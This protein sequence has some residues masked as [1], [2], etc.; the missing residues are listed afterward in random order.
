MTVTRKTTASQRR[1][2]VVGEGTSRFVATQQQARAS[3]SAGPS[4]GSGSSRVRE[5]IA[6]NPPEFTG[7]DQR[8]DL[9]DFIDHLHM[10]I[11]VMHATEK[12][13][14]KLSAFRLRDIAIFWYEGWEK[15]RGRYA[16]PT[17]WEKFSDV[18]LDL[19][20]SREI[21]QT[22]LNQFL[23]LKQGNMSVREYNL[24]FD[25]LERYAPSIVAT[26]RDRVH[27]FIARLAPELTEACA[28]AALQD[29]MDISRI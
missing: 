29:R 17:I 9:Q 25:S 15:S 23:A 28:S 6:L 12:E 4:E 11:R 3:A 13:A 26:M 1:E 22:R 27:R 14:V 8:E 5:F 7:T 16:P 24:R 2:I 18:F 19:Y 10:I 20:L 21:R